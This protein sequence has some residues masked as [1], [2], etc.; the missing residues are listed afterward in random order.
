MSDSYFVCAFYY[1]LLS[2]EWDRVPVTQVLCIAAQGKIRVQLSQALNKTQREDFRDCGE[3]HTKK[4]KSSTHLYRI[5]KHSEAASLDHSPDWRL[6][7]TVTW[8]TFHQ[9]RLWWSYGAAKKSLLSRQSLKGEAVV[10][11]GKGMKITVGD[12]SLS[13]HGCEL[14]RETEDCNPHTYTVLQLVTTTIC[15]PVTWRLMATW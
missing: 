12:P 9:E 6:L 11:G 2:G 4:R 1:M 10:Q 7:C 3:K 14:K 13:F 8:L 15:K 5:H